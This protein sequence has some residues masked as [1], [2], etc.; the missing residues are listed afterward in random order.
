MNALD[1]IEAQHLRILELG[2]ELMTAERPRRG[3]L[4]R[5]LERVIEAHSEM[6]ELLFYPVFH[7]ASSHDALVQYAEDHRQVRKLL[8]ALDHAG[9]DSPQFHRHVG[10][11]MEAFEAHAYDEEEAKLLPLVERRLAIVQLHVLGSEMFALYS[12]LVAH[13]VEMNVELES[14]RP[15][16]F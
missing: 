7:T 16:L 11:V 12:E 10:A 14:R 5:Q 3:L 8:V 9:L 2:R 15:A 1:L 4:A 13:P 6:E